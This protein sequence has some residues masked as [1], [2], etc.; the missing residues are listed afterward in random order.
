MQRD[1]GLHHMAPESRLTRLERF[2]GRTQNSELTQNSKLKTEYRQY[3]SGTNRRLA[4]VASS[5]YSCF[6]DR[7]GSFT[8]GRSIFLWGISFKR[9][10]MRFSRA[11][12]LSSERTMYQGA[13]RVS[14]ALSMASRARE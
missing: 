11:R 2:Q 14:V 5:S 9:C 8:F 10:E 4:I 13:C 7:P 1:V 6:R 3:T 12:F